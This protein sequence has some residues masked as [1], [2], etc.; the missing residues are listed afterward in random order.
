[1]NVRKL[2]LIG[3]HREVFGEGIHLLFQEGEDLL[4]SGKARRRPLIMETMG[5]FYIVR[6][7][8]I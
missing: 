5:S 3:C 2:S 7:L 4:F 6:Y 1:M 8:E